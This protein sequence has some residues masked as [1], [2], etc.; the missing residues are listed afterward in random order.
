MVRNPGEPIQITV[1]FAKGYDGLVRVAVLR[2]RRLVNLID[3]Q[4]EI[5]TG[6][7]SAVIEIDES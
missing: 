6:P 3:R 5:Y 4:L 7:T 1:R 2:A